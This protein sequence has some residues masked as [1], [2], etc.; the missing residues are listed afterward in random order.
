M[1][2]PSNVT[3]PVILQPSTRSF[4]LFNDFNNVDFPHPD[5]P[6]NAVISF[7]GRSRL[8]FFKALNFP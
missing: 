2:S 8:I 7:W 3:F 4:I 5:G 6:I 1:S